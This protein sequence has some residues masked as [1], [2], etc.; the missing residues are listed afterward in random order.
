MNLIVHMNGYEND[1]QNDPT[2]NSF[3]WHREYLGLEI[4]QPV[5]KLISLASGESLNLFS[6]SVSLNSDATTTYDIALKSGTSSIY[7]ISHNSGTAPL[8]RTPRVSGAAADTE[9]S[10]TKNGKVLT[11]TSTS[12][13]AF[14]LVT[15][16]VQVGDR[17]RIGTLFNQSNQGEFKII[18][19]S[20]TSFSIENETGVEESSI[21]L[22]ADFDQQVN[23]YTSAGVQ[24]GDKLA[25]VDGFSLVSQGTYEI[26]DVSHD[27]IEFSSIGVLPS[28]TAVSN[29]PSAISIYQSSQQFVYIESDGKL[30]IKIN[31]S[32]VTNIIEPFSINGV[33]KPGMFLTKSNITSLTIE[34]PT[35]DICRVYCITAE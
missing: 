17:V 16:L 20:A 28:E 19:R 34:N 22:G 10:V 5:S 1:N 30:N 3:K 31:G 11:F 13:T 23:I 27:Y 32:V 18:A 24:I 15:G 4:D 14:S 29:S 7:V 9:V 26:T 8:F 2:L 12:G 6:G 33:V 25:I 35:T 21:V